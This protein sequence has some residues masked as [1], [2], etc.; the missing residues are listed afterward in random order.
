ML[1]N[2]C[3]LRNLTEKAKELV[4]ADPIQINW[5]DPDK[6]PETPIAPAFSNR[7]YVAKVAFD[8][9]MKCQAF[10]DRTGLAIRG[11]DATFDILTTAL[12]TV[13]TAVT[14]IATTHA[15]SAAAAI[16]SGTKSAI[17]ADVYAKQTAW[18]IAQQI[19]STY[20]A[21]FKTYADKLLNTT[22]DARIYP[23]AEILQIAYIHRE[24]DIDKALAVLASKS[25]TPGPAPVCSKAP[26][27]AAQ[28]KTAAVIVSPR[29]CTNYF[30]IAGPT[31]KDPDKISY[32]AM[33][34]GA[35]ARTGSAAKFLQDINP[36]S[37]GA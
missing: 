20:F 9:A 22:D 32:V 19:D 37:P 31:V 1:L 16:S 36:A 11:V 14:P 3:A 15:L 23:P 12:S 2:G 17:D 5:P 28:L 29:D 30:I 13:A 21:D 26:V 18:L 7:A 27:T 25:Q 24:C 6:G 4:R 33:T 8:S 34:A 10:L 35:V